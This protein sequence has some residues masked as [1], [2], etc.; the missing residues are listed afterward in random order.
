MINISSTY[1]ILAEP[2]KLESGTWKTN[3]E[4]GKKLLRGTLRGDTLERSVISEKCP[5]RGVS[6]QR[7]VPSEEC[8]LREVSPQRS[9]PYE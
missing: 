8:P 6:P 9:V 2:V 1:N 3:L 7:S 4:D 5:L